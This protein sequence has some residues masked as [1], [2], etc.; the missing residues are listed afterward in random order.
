MAEFRSAEFKSS[1]AKVPGT[2]QQETRVGIGVKVRQLLTGQHI[3]TEVRGSCPAR[4]ARR[5][6]CR[7]Q[8]AAQRHA[9]Y[10]G[11]RTRLA[12]RLHALP[13][14][15]A[16]AA[17]AQ[18]WA[19]GLLRRRALTRLSSRAVCGWTQLVP[20]SAADNSPLEVGEVIQSVN[21][22]D[23]SYCSTDHLADLLLGP[24]GTRVCVCRCACAGLQARCRLAS[25]KLMS[26]AL[27]VA[28]MLPCNPVR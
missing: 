2:L 18:C 20:G 16:H 24:E 25:A 10:R 6:L 4:R 1:D 8:P 15:A 21:G 23:C 14:R 7:E 11:L 27:S 13:C 3:I 26:V 5:V 22:T 17:G 28:L 12:R 19:A 9:A